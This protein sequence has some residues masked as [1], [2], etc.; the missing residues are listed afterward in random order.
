MTPHYYATIQHAQVQKQ[1]KGNVVTSVSAG[2]P[3]IAR[4]SLRRCVA[5]P[6]C[7]P[8][9]NSL[10]ASLLQVMWIRRR[11]WHI[12]TS[13][14]TT[15]TTDERYEVVHPEDADE[16]HLVI[17]YVQKRDNGTYECQVS[18][19]FFLTLSYIFLLFLLWAAA[20][21]GDAGPLEPP[22]CCDGRRAPHP[23]PPIRDVRG[24]NSSPG[25]T[26]SF[27][28]FHSSNVVCWRG[29]RGA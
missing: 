10:T 18:T 13:G 16:W 5:G 6:T 1:L 9:L 21:D 14:T 22:R 3:R 15:Y 12:L 11:D 7:P 29:G 28:Y 27:S 26:K 8:S 23:P 20:S 19:T 2:V 17:R 25:R 24:R 4:V